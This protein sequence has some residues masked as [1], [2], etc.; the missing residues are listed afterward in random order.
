[1]AV[2]TMSSEHRILLSLHPWQLYVGGD[3]FL[4][5]SL[6]STAIPGEDFD[7]RWASFIIRHDD[8]LP[9][10]IS[11]HRHLVFNPSSSLQLVT[12]PR[13]IG[14]AQPFG[15]SKP[16]FPKSPG[17]QPY[18]AS[19]SPIVTILPSSATTT[20]SPSAILPVINIHA[21]PP[22]HSTSFLDH[23]LDHDHDHG[24]ALPRFL[25]FSL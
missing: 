21:S 24:R 4:S 18:C 2:N 25:P 8:D 15:C 10:P 14:I 3:N 19:P 1:M 5:S 17:I 9:S 20:K 11:R 22:R 6:S 7:G 16:R 23:D 12:P 13:S